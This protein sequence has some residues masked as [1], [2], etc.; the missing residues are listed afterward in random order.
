VALI[1]E[2]LDARRTHVVRRL[3]LD[4]AGIVLGRALTSAI[5]LDD[6]HVDA[7]H[8][9]I[10]RSADGLLTLTD[11]D[12]VNGI[13]SAGQGRV[14]ELP[15][16]AGTQFRIGRT[17]FRVVDAD[18]PVPPALPL[19]PQHTG[20][21]PW[22]ER[23][24]YQL[25]APLAILVILGVQTYL[26]TATR[27]AGTAALGVVIAVAIMMAMWSGVWALVGR[28]LVRRPAFLAHTAVGSGTSVVLVAATWLTVWA[29][30]LFPA[31]SPAWSTF[32]SV[33]SI[34]IFII[35]TYWQLGLATA[36]PARKRWIG[37]VGTVVLFAGIV[38]AFALVADDGF[39]D[40]PEFHGTIRY[41]PAAMIP[42]ISVDDF[43]VTIADVRTEVDSLRSRGDDAPGR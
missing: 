1:L 23:G 35:A 6:P 29:T 12:S 19:A 16:V 20:P 15:L 13:E 32:D 8:A 26:D 14:A 38:G 4:A 11:L 7:S 2:Q 42:A 40:V 34:A 17:P 9:R 5:V 43:R 36:M 28:A 10:A 27:E 18:A 25:L 30:F 3:A 31:W 22:F 21:A 37:A 39:T 33:V 24:W 41:A